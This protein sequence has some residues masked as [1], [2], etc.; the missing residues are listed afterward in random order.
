MAPLVTWLAGSGANNFDTLQEAI[1][2]SF[3]G[4]PCLRVFLAPNGPGSLEDV[5]LGDGPLL[6]VIGDTLTNPADLAGPDDLVV[7]LPAPNPVELY[8]VSA[9]A[10]ALA[11]LYRTGRL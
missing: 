7:N 9:A 4:G 10:A 3:A 2:A 11:E 8:G 1:D 6:L 5:P